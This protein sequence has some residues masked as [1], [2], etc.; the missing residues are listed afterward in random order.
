YDR[1]REKDIEVIVSEPKIIAVSRDKQDWY[2]FFAPLGC[3]I[4]P[5]I[6]VKDFLERPDENTL[7]AIVKPSGGS[8]SQGIYIV[9]DLSELEGLNGDDI[10]QPYLFPETTDENYQSIYK[11]V[12]TGKFLQKSEI[13]IQLVFSKNSKLSGIF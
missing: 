1:F 11:A 5:T 12:K 10:I 2:N 4:V 8:A 3:K 9:N 13:S 6:S 7:P